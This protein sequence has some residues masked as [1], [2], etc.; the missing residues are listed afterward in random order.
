[1]SN[2]DEQA[3]V[4]PSSD[5]KPANQSSRY[6]DATLLRSAFPSAIQEVVEALGEVTIV[7]RREGLLELLGFLKHDAQFQ[8]HYLSDLS[9]LDLGEFATPRFAVN[10]HLYSLPLN[11]RVRVKLYLDEDDAHAPTVSGIW[12]TANW[13]EREVFDMYGITFDGHPD[14]RRI[15]MPADYE[16]HPLRKDFPIKGY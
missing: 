11:H 15:L 2:A 16:G 10:Y 6:A 12:P 14:L 5:P 4:D 9:G 13:H 3:S 8:F 1:M 7:A